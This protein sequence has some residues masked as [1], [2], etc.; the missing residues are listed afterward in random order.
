MKAFKKGD[1]VT[2]IQTWNRTGTC[3]FQHAV[4]YSCGKKQM[5]LTCAATGEEMGRHYAPQ[6]GN[7]FGGTFPRMTDDEAR[8]AALDA[9]AEHIVAER[10]HFFRMIERNSDAGEGYLNA[11]NEGVEAL[12]EPRALNLG[13]REAVDAAMQAFRDARNAA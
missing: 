12:H 8:K 7:E 5:V 11:M 13:D 1:L 9:A 4:V 6:L 2:H 3:T 10:E